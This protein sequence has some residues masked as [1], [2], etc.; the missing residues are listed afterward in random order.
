M[1]MEM[2]KL[3]EVVS[4]KE[5][6]SESKNPATNRLS[7]AEQ[8]AVSH[9]SKPVEKKKPSQI[10]KYI[11]T[12]EQEREA[13][14]EASRAKA[15]VLSEK[16]I[17][18]MYPESHTD[19]IDSV[20]VDVPLLIRLLE[21]AKEDAKTD[22][23][24]HNVAE[25]LIELSKNKRP[26]TM[27]D[28]SSIVQTQD[29]SIDETVNDD[30][31]QLLDGIAAFFTQAEAEHPTAM[32]I[33]KTI[34]EVAPVSGQ[35]AGGYQLSTHLQNKQ[36]KDALLDL[37]TMIPGVAFIGKLQKFKTVFGRF[38]PAVTG[39]KYDQLIM[40]LNN[41]LAAKPVQRTASL[42]V[43]GTAAAIQNF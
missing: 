26:L 6:I 18:K 4:S 39:A 12:I 43:Q 13:L 32:A 22:L 37:I 38:L 7:M 23:D 41:A 40:K 42:P 34:F 9:Y 11:E 29:R 31:G 30:I 5:I 16:V 17:Q 8:M 20:T 1:N 10:T 27:D 21:Y 35:L 3:L 14:Q 19:K 33:I 15:R 2:K 28:Y 36:Y 25:R 24:L